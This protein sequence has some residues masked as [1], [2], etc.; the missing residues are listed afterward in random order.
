M[1]TQLMM[2]EEKHKSEKAIPEAKE[3]ERKRIAADLH[4]NIGIYAASIV[5]NINH[6][7]FTPRD[8]RD[9]RALNELRLNSQAIISQ[10]SDTIWVLKKESMP[11][12]AISD[13]LK[14]F[15]QRLQRRDPDV[16]IE[17]KKNILF[18]SL[19]TFH[20]FHILQEA[21]S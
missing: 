1:K 11:I 13:R 19:Q 12:L 15:V 4:D 10:L 8:T 3:S 6:I 9:E 20:L 2:Q 5:S 7:H 16:V 21:G 17:V 14:L 18:Y